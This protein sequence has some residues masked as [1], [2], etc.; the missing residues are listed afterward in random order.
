MKMKNRMNQVLKQTSYQYRFDWGEAALKYSGSESDVVAIV[1]IL[2]FTTAVSIAVDR[3]A[4]VYP[5]RWKDDSAVS[6]A[7]SVDH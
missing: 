6:F 3:G 5:Y 1:D 7:R 2:S 4:T